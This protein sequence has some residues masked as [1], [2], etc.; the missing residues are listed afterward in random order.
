MEN[1]KVGAQL[2]Y[3]RYILKFELNPASD[4]GAV[5]WTK[6]NNLLRAFSSFYSTSRFGEKRDHIVLKKNNKITSCTFD[7][8]PFFQKIM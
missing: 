5:D 8:K 1:Q 2:I 3:I 4:I 7:D 6:S